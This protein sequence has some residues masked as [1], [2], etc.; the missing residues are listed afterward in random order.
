M[1]R[2]KIAAQPRPAPDVA[3]PTTPRPPAV[4]PTALPVEIIDISSIEYVVDNHRTFMDE[5]KLAELA[6]SIRGMGV[7]QP[8][9]VCRRDDRHVMIFGH[10]RVKASTLAG[11]ATVPAIIAVGLTDQQIAEAQMIE[12]IHREDI[13]PIGEA[14]CVDVLVKA[15]D[16][17]ELAASKLGRPVRWAKD[18]HRLMRL[19]KDVQDLIQRGR[20]PV[21]YGLEIS[22]VGD[23]KKQVV[24]AHHAIGVHS[25]QDKGTKDK[26]FQGDYLKPLDDIRKDISY[27]LCKMGSA[28]WPKDEPYAGMRPCADC[29]DNTNTEPGLFDNIS[30]TS[31]KGNCTNKKCYEA[32]GKAWEKD[33]VKK[34]RDKERQQKAEAA[35]KNKPGRKGAAGNQEPERRKFPDSPSEHFA[36][37]LH[38]YGSGLVDLIRKWGESK[39]GPLYMS[40]DLLPPVLAEV[41]H[42]WATMSCLSTWGRGVIELQI[43][44]KNALAP[45][46]LMALLSSDNPFEIPLGMVASMVADMRSLDFEPRYMSWDKRVEN[47]PIPPNVVE[48]IGCLEAFCKRRGIAVKAVRPLLIAENAAEPAPTLA[49]GVKGVCRVCGC[50]EDKACKGGCSWVDGPKK[51]LCSCCLDEATFSEIV[52]GVKGTSLATIKI[53]KDHR[54]LKAARDYGLLG[55]WRRL[56]VAKRIAELQKAKPAKG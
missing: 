29:P 24:L 5:A 13:G 54:I 3:A 32:K 44:R 23:E 33:P 40:Q 9:K 2:T 28:F 26:R 56:A 21:G 8:I 10:R 22:K 18:R 46:Q 14:I 27:Y 15:G 31:A 37:V 4:E 1:K 39:T 43:G 48:Y 55:D 52:L 38:K 25:F 45:G 53:I 11:L 7:Q 20:L 47:V 35:G 30:L 49:E 19:H 17:Y 34:A 42:L 41:A 16:S 50:T 12:N 51:T 36:V 6:E